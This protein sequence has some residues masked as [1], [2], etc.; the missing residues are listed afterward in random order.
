MECEYVHLGNLADLKF[1]RRRESILEKQAGENTEQ[2]IYACAERCRSV[3]THLNAQ[4]G[5][6]S[7]WYH[8]IHSASRGQ[9][10]VV[11]VAL[12]GQLKVKADNVGDFDLGDVGVLLVEAPVKVSEVEDGAGGRRGGTGSRE[13]R[14]RVRV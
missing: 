13:L 11:H 14:L 8:V 9:P 10:R 1:P 2:V 5:L 3:P 12:R 4:D 7:T 6:F